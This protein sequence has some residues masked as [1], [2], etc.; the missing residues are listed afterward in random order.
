M[1]KKD[2]YQKLIKGIIIVSSL[3]AAFLHVGKFT[4]LTIPSILFYILHVMIGFVLAFI[5]YPLG[6]KMKEKTKL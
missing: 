5:Y 1:E 6:R 4:I 2:T 3:F